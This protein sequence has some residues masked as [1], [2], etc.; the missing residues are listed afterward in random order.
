M[1]DE[2]YTAQIPVVTSASFTPNPARINSSVRLQ[3]FCADETVILYPSYYQAG[4]IQC[5]EG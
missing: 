1:N 5:G 3:V 2:T 4:E